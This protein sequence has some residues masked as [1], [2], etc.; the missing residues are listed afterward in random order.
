MSYTKNTWQTGDIVSSEKLNHMEDGIADGSFPDYTNTDVGK[1][2]T[3]KS[4]S[5]SLV[6][7]WEDV[8]DAASGVSF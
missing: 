5:G 6:L 3:V 4:S 7:A 8:A 2:L 1:V